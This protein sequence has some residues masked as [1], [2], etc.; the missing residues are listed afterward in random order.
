MHITISLCGH[1]IYIEGIKVT[2]Y[3]PL[4]ATY[5]Y[6]YCNVHRYLIRYPLTPLQKERGEKIISKL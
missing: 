2:H 3:Q 1:I 4:C 6:L 5:S